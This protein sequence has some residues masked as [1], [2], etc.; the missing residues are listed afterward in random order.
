MSG[1]QLTPAQHR[2]VHERGG[3]T[4]VSAGAGA[5]KTRVL[6]ER[7]MAWIESGHELKNFL[8]ITYTKA[9]AAELRERIFS[10]LSALS[11]QRPGDH[12][13]R[14]QMFSL[15][16]CDICTVH[17]LC[18]RILEEHPA[19]GGL[20]PGA[21][22]LDETERTQLLGRT[23]EDL[24][25]ERYETMDDPFAA[26][27]SATTDAGGDR[28]LVQF[29]LTG[30]EKTHGHPDPDGWMDEQEKAFESAAKMPVEKNFWGK[31]LLDEANRMIAYGLDLLRRIYDEIQDTPPVLA[32][33]GPAFRADILWAEQMESA[34]AQGWEPAN[35]MA[36]TLCH[37]PLK[38]VRGWE[39]KDFLARCKAARDS[40]KKRAEKLVS[41]LSGSKD[42]HKEDFRV[43]LPVARGLFDTVSRLSQ[44]LDIQKRRLN[45]YDFH[46]LERRTL[47]LLTEENGTM[48]SP[49]A[50]HLSKRYTEIMV[51]EY[52]DIS[53]IQEHIV[54]ALSRHGKNLYWV[55]DVR[56][57]IYRFRL[58][59]PTLFLTKYND[60]PDKAPDGQPRRILLGDNFRS[61]PEV[62]NAVN[63]LFADIMSPQ[64]GEMAYTEREYLHAAGTFE[65]DNAD[66]RCELLL[67]DASPNSDHED[68]EGLSR[69]QSEAV[70]LASRVQT[71]LREA[72]PVTG[73]DGMRRPATPGDIAIL[74][75]APSLR[76]A[77]F[78]RALTEAGI[79]CHTDTNDA[80]FMTPEILTAL[81]LLRVIDNPRQDIALLAALRCP[82]WDFDTGR[83][84]GMRAA[85][86]DGDL[87]DTLTSAECRG[88]TAASAFL[89][90]LSHW[91]LLASDLTAS[92]L[93]SRVYVDTHL[94]TLY[95]TQ[96][97]G[98]VRRA[99][100]ERLLDMASAFDTGRARGLSDFLAWMDGL[101]EKGEPAARPTAADAVSIMSIHR[102]K[103]LEFPI[104]ILADAAKKFSQADARA[105]ILFHPRAGLGLT[106]RDDVR[107]IEYPTLSR[108]AVACLLTGE[109]LAEEMRMLYVA[110]TR[111][112]EKL[113]ITA[114]PTRI[115]TTLSNRDSGPLPPQMVSEG[116]SYLDWLSMHLAGQDG[117]ALWRVET[118]QPKELHQIDTAE[119][120]H[121][122][123]NSAWTPPDPQLV[124]EMVRRMTYVYPHQDAAMLPSKLTATSLKG[125]GLDLEA[126]QDTQKPHETKPF[127]RP[128]FVREDASV[129]SPAERGTALHLFMQF[130]DFA[131]CLTHADA[132]QE[133]MRLTRNGFLTEAQ[134][135]AVNA[136]R[137]AAFFASPLGLRMMKAETLRR[138]FKFSLLLPAEELTG[139][140]GDEEIL[141]Q[142]VVDCYFEQP[143]GLVVVDFKTDFVR[144]GEEQT[145]AQIYQ[146]QV[147]A[148][149][150]ALRAITEKPVAEC[151][152]Y[153]FSTGQTVSLDI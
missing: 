105:P 70:L 85:C 64:T 63:A 90:C 112:R 28:K 35:T 32:A 57:S 95:G 72:F 75:R 141:F 76:A 146:P 27:V 144:A 78:S 147:S 111:A 1:F 30:F 46:D 106:R 82:S 96:P 100:L 49:V 74:L 31:I 4:L 145:R 101:S 150:R 22:L 102:S 17:A 47:A 61:R 14:R 53:L 122:Q 126:A 132:E 137:I 98:P 108:R 138:E 38:G 92:E 115:G 88:D 36:Q 114:A 25:E 109:M 60:F 45:V 116:R 104:V 99:N 68:D 34:I 11:A 21:R 80:F 84:A 59:E 58:A 65:E 40:W 12:R 3:A 44:A 20:R 118:I 7:L 51:D 119:K 139:Q 94:V 129:L 148:Y 140:G 67:A 136:G 110:M 10:A 133:K 128:R 134:A 93:L 66:H 18:K 52:Q 117:A 153:F 131:H 87:I 33:Y 91:R 113:I 135:D 39:D 69:V 123:D 29:V 5:G 24:L 26:L 54:Q 73:K 79:P 83:L 37:L 9:A 8:V 6:V 55:G 89:A 142:G 151:L 23:L 103:G 2:A 48:P 77:I 124:D 56:Q 62:L 50:T 143:E 42:S 16:G 41:L 43:L 86:P 15:S 130:A 127:D 121:P 71:L 149:A 13:L 152:L 120:A 107:M 125:R 97:D 19:V 81:A